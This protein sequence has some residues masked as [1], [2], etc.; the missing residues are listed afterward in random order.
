MRQDCQTYRELFL[1]DVPLLDVRAPIEFAKG[2]FP[3]AVNLPLM[4]DRQREMVGTCYKQHGQQAAIALGHRL[5]SG[6]L[7]QARIQAWLTFAQAHPDGY[8]YCFRGG[9]RSQIV[10]SWLSSEAGVA[11]PRVASGYKAMRGFLLATLQSALHECRVMVLGGM[12]GTGKTDVL[13]TLAYALDLEHHA[14]HRGSSF[15]K[16]VQPQPVQVGFDNALAIDVLRKRHLG[17]ET[18]LVEDEGQAIGSCSLP[19]DLYRLMQVSPLVWLE[20]SLTHRVERI[21]RDYVIDLCADF[22]QR[23]GQ[24]QGYIAFAQRLQDSLAAIRKRL[25]G[26]RYQQIAALMNAALT[27]QAASGDI[28]AHR[29]WITALLTQYYDPMYSYQ[30]KA[31][32]DRIVFAGDERAVLD[33]LAHDRSRQR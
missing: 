4:D 31:K 11:Y 15:G 8:L 14:C 21:L 29:A 1:A 12:T 16:R 18:F 13:R 30:R 7:K 32:Q 3:G 20:D 5:V 23:D 17:H 6:A 28:Q 9:L 19:P 2:A 27:R 26:L 10:Q 22:V 25:G 24:E 33:Y